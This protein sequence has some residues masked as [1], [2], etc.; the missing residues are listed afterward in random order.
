LVIRTLIRSEL[1]FFVFGDTQIPLKV[2]VFSFCVAVH[3]F[4]ITS[5]LGIVRWKKLE[6]RHCSAPK[7]VHHCLFTKK[8]LDIPMGGDGTEVDD[9]HPGLGGREFFI[10]FE[11]GHR[12]SFDSDRITV[13]APASGTISTNKRLGNVPPFFLQ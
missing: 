11:V 8:S 2:Q 1:L 7:F 10:N 9:S 6:P 4:A 12:C 5:E 13:P 3:S